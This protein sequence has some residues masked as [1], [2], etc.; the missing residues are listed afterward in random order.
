NKALRFAKIVQ[1]KKTISKN[2]DRD[3]GK[4]SAKINKK[5]RVK[6]RKNKILDEG[7]DDQMCLLSQGDSE[8]DESVSMYCL[9]ASLGITLDGKPAR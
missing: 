7:D 2:K 9:G 4:I 8:D 6:E 1:E 3:S 5:S